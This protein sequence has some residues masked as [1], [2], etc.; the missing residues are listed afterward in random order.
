MFVF[1][2]TVEL[3]PS[4]IVPS[5]LKLT[6]EQNLKFPFF[7]ESN[8]PIVMQIAGWN[9]LIVVRLDQELSD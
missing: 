8:Q 5:S 3:P 6:S 7:V 9:F 2:I 1:G 4:L